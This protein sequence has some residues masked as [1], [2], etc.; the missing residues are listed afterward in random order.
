MKMN[1]ILNKFIDKNKII[2]KRKTRKYK[3]I[4]LKKMFVSKI[5]YDDALMKMYKK[6]YFEKDR[7]IDKQKRYLIFARKKDFIKNF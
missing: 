4:L 7:M 6:G 3:P 2:D 5:G 1:E